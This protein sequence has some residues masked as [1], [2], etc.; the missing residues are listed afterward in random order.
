MTIDI[1]KLKK[2]HYYNE[3]KIKELELKIMKINTENKEIELKLYNMQAAVF[4]N[5]SGECKI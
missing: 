2:Q 3:L 1:I 5:K 4:K